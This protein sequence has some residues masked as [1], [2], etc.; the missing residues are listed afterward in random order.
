MDGKLALP[1][2]IEVFDDK[3]RRE[4]VEYQ[5]LQSR[6]TVGVDAFTPVGAG[7]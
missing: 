1:M 7:L 6:L 2:K 5:N 3:G 4:Y